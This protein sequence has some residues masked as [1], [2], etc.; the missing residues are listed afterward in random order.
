MFEKA[1]ECFAAKQLVSVR[2]KEIKIDH[3]VRRRTLQAYALQHPQSR[4][5]FLSELLV[6]RIAFS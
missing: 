2:R 4:I 1:K 5:F 6:L 3:Y